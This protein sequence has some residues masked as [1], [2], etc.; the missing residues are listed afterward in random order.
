MK[1]GDLVI[2]KNNKYFIKNNVYRIWR[3]YNEIPISDEGIRGLI[4]RLSHVRYGNILLTE[5][6]LKCDKQ[7]EPTN[8]RFSLIKEE[9]L[10]LLDSRIDR[11]AKKYKN[12]TLS[13]NELKLLDEYIKMYKEEHNV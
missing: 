7:L 6:G 10:E 9:D 11:L 4:H 13:K 3:K 12:K 5:T 2:A 1:Q 8:L